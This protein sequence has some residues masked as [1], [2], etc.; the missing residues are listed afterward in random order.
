MTSTEA[1][2]SWTPEQKRRVRAAAAGASIKLREYDNKPVPQ[3]LRDIAAG[4]DTALTDKP[5]R[6]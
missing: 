1:R 4:E 3:W 2:R 5:D 6:S